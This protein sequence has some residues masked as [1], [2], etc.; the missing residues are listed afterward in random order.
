MEEERPQL[1]LM[2]SILE[3]DDVPV[4]FISAY[5]QDDLVARAFEMGAADYMVEPFSPTEHSARIRTALRRRTVPDPLEL[6]VHGTLM[7]DFA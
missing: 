1:D 2:Q 7:I 3:I 6:Y 4:I 5:G